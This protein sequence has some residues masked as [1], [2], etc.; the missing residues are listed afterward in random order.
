M[1][2]IFDH[3]CH[4]LTSVVVIGRR[5]REDDEH[6]RVSRKSFTSK[7]TTSP[8]CTPIADLSDSSIYSQRQYTNNPIKR[9]VCS[10]NSKKNNNNHEHIYNFNLRML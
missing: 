6:A 3:I 5:R 7:I 4:I 9:N 10:F 2:D 8:S 1:V